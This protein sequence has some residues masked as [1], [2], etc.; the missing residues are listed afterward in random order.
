MVERYSDMN[1][2]KIK[3]DIMLGK[4]VNGNSRNG[5]R[6]RNAIQQQTIVCSVGE[7]E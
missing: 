7:N 1:K 3:D 4:M 5:H 6:S 2:G